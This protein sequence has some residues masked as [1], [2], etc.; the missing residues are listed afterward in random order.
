MA[1][2][3]NA[4]KPA[5]Q[6]ML[7]DV[8]KLISAYYTQQPDVE[9]PG[10]QV[11][12]G[13]SGHRG[14][15]LKQSFNDMHIAAIAQAIAE[16]RRAEGVDGPLMIGLDT[17]ALAWPAFVTALEVLVAN[18]VPV[19]Y[20]EG[21]R[22]TPT[23]VISQA[24]IAY[25][26]GRQGGLADGVV[27]T[28]SHNPPED[29]GFKYNPTHGG[30]ADTDAT[31]KIQDRANA[32]MRAENR[33]VR[34]LPFERAIKSALAR[35][36][37]FIM[38]YV[39]VLG[40]VIDMQAIARAGVSIG[41]DPLG[42]ANLPFFE[43]IAEVYGLDLHVVNDRVDPR[44]AFMTCDHDG[45]IRMDCSSAFAMASLIDLK[46][47][48]D[49][50][51]G[52][53][54]DGDR[55]GIVTPEGGLM[56]PNHYLAV[57]IEYLFTHRPEWGPS[58]GIGKTVVSSSL[59]DRVAAGL[60]RP[61][62]EVPVGIKWFQPGLTAGTLGFGGEESAGATFLRRD[63]GVWTTDKDGMILGLLA[64]EML[65]V[66]ERD[67]W[68]RFNDLADHHGMPYYARRDAAANRSQKAVL[69]SL[70]PEAVDAQTLAGEPIEHR[71]TR[72]PGNDAPLGGLKVTTPNGWFA[73]R[74]SGT[75][76]I[77]K[78]YA[79]SFVSESHLE[80][81]QSEAE[82]IVSAALARAGS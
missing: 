20:Q 19:I 61:L 72:A 34:R 57:C 45:K 1:V 39:K 55:H 74:P 59:I 13:T 31:R 35:P 42:G 3:P 21:H 25:N 15:S 7:V 5:T 52:N 63:G 40:S 70:S 24:I 50:A 51:F 29:G 10:Q 37:D 27:V 46:D 4:G 58:L 11:S 65:A 41:V 16:Y 12:F 71:L 81:I 54:T 33:E 76:D 82:A 17:H 30:P 67:P 56:N 22:P 38:P 73:A 79:E 60:G 47:R 66:T 80:Q 69:A 36:H 23:P 8:P 26:A 32:L 6:D 62:V 75:E 53:D 49:I 9:D 64:A 14:S 48:Y 44:F 43:P 78:I 28:P 18:D 68:V 2:H 77:Y